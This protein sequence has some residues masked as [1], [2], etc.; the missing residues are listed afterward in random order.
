MVA[1]GVHRARVEGVHRGRRRRQAARSSPTLGLRLPG[2]RAPLLHVFQDRG[3]AVC[4]ATEGRGA[5]TA[6]SVMEGGH[7]QTE[8]R[9]K[10]RGSVNGARSRAGFVACLSGW[11]LSGGVLSDGATL[12]CGPEGELES[13]VGGGNGTSGRQSW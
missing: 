2:R 3:L 13:G 6:L 4:T 7:L 12:P 8:R 1:R 9:V 5:C 11:S 10:A